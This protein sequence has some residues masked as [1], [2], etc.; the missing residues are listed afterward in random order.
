MFSLRRTLNAYFL[1]TLGVDNFKE[2]GIVYRYNTVTLIDTFFFYQLYQLFN[3]I[4]LILRT[5]KG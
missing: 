5:R 2:T 1:N 3:K 4:G